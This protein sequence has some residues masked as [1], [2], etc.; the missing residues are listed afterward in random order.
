M[1]A[2]A[3]TAVCNGV[4]ATPWPKEM[5]TELI[6]FQFLGWVGVATPGISVSILVRSPSFVRNC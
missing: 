3:A 1:R 5:V 6:F 2:A 4:V